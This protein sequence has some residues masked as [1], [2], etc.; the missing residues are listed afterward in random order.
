MNDSARPQTA[1]N[2]DRAI[3][4]LRSLTTGTALAGF[5]ATGAFGALAAATYSGHTSTATDTTGTGKTGRSATQ[6]ST[7]ND[8]TTTDNSNS[9]STLNSTLNAATTQRQKAYVTTGGSG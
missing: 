3:G 5:V 4:R 8:Q 6:S 7:T 9:S 2:R 1:R